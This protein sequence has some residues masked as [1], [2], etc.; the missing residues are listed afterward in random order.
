M[1]GS[2]LYTNNTNIQEIMKGQMI[3]DIHMDPYNEIPYHIR[4]TSAGY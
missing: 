4:S 3:L 1:D 2:R